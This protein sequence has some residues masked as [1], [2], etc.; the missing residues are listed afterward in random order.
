MDSLT[1]PGTLDSLKPIRDFI[2]AA[3]AKAGLGPKASYSLSLAV[4]EVATNIIVHGYEEAG[5]TGDL[6]IAFS[7][8]SET[9]K[10]ILED[11]AQEFDPS[12]RE[13]PTDEDLSRPLE[14]RPIG[15]LG[16]FLTMDGVD[17]FRYERI[18]NKN[19][20]I[21]VVNLRSQPS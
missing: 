18:G 10:I 21:F 19:R 11:S 15:G 2:K 16:I 9:L 6:E 13:L 8:D 5:L 20:N 17:D 12:R 14:E 3:A 7:I 4:D 1:L